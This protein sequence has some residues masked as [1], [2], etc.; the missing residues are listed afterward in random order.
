MACK[1]DST[2]PRD[3]TGAARRPSVSTSSAAKEPD[4][5]LSKIP[6][7]VLLGQ[8]VGLNRIRVVN[9]QNFR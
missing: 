4:G 1:M 3:A 2:A 8:A 6:N 9:L 7:L 5:Q